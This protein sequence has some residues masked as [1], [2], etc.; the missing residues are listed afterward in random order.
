MR[1]VTEV[2]DDS[3]VGGGGGGGGGGGKHGG[4]PGA[5]EID[6][7]IAF[8]SMAPGGMEGQIGDDVIPGGS[9]A[10]PDST[11]CAQKQFK[12]IR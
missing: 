9:N 8:C 7:G 11:K 1:S 5:R 6:D 10:T 2:L 12:L 4:P 3:G